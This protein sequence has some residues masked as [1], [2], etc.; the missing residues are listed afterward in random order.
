MDFANSFSDMPDAGASPPAAAGGG[1]GK[2]IGGQ[3]AESA[4]FMLSCGPSI[5]MFAMGALTVAIRGKKALFDPKAAEFNWTMGKKIVWIVKAVLT[6]IVGSMVVAAVC[7]YLSSSIA[8]PF[9]GCALCCFYCENKGDV[10]D[11]IWSN[12][13]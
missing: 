3:I 10:D 12:G 7:K 9:I 8:Y 13:A 5:M 11:L 1:I 4:K 2:R 6:A